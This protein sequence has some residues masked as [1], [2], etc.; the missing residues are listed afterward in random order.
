MEASGGENGGDGGGDGGGTGTEDSTRVGMSSANRILSA[1]RSRTCVMFSGSWRS[2]CKADGAHDHRTTTPEGNE[3]TEQAHCPARRFHR[4][5]TSEPPI[6]RYT[7]D[8]QSADSDTRCSPGSRRR[9]PFRSQERGLLRV[10]FRVVCFICPLKSSLPCLLIGSTDNYPP[11]PR[12]RPRCSRSGFPGHGQRPGRLP[13]HC[14]QAKRRQPCA[15]FG[16]DGSGSSRPRGR[17]RPAAKTPAAL[18]MPWSAPAG[19]TPRGR[20]AGRAASPAAYRHASGAALGQPVYDC[21]HS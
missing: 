5:R 15:D 14:L 9:S 17:D 1:G 16:P 8:E 18:S 10:N 4:R 7:G 2:D 19:S 13:A 3:R 11:S 6:T 12:T 21:P 20:V